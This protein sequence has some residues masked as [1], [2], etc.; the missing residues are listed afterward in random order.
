MSENDPLIVAQSFKINPKEVA[1]L[2]HEKILTLSKA[3]LSSSEEE[4]G[5]GTELWV[6]RH[7]IT[8]QPGKY[9]VTLGATNSKGEVE[10]WEVAVT[11]RN[12]KKFLL[13]LLSLLA[14]L[15]LAGGLWWY[16]SRPNVVAS[17]LPAAT[18]EKMSPVDLKKY[19][20]KAVDQSNV[21]VQVY[22]HVYIKEDGQIGKMYVQNVP[23]NKTGQV[24]TLKD[25]TT[26][27]VLYTSE[28]LKPGYQVSQVTLKKKL[29][30]GDHPGT[31][32]LTFYD[33]KEE[34][35]VGKVNVAVTIHVGNKAS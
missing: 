22:P 31:V 6:V 5:E 16:N 10:T 8:T 2:S 17:G 14:L 7:N 32:T 29:S 12:R 23:V 33:L 20:Q 3:S 25:K 15:A 26:G 13:L 24:A 30:K 27:E 18:T 28:L 35:Q 9:S 4:G 11:V 34:K 1:D 19:A 21:T